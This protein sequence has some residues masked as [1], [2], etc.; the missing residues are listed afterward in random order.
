MHFVFPTFLYAFIALSIPII[1]HLFYFRKYKKVYFP[2]IRFLKKLQEQK[3][4]INQLKQRLILLARLAAIFFL[5]LAFAQ[6]FFGKKETGNASN[7]FS[8]VYIDNSPST[9]LVKNGETILDIEKNQAK[10]V[11]NALNPD[12]K[13]ALITNDLYNSYQRWM[14]KQDFIDA[15]D[16]IKPSKQ[17]KSLEEVFLKQNTLLESAGSNQK[18]RFIFS[19]F[20]T[21]IIDNLKID[22]N[23]TTYLLP[24]QTKGENNVFVDTCW[25]G[26]PI[27][28]LNTNNKLFVRFKNSG[29]K[30]V[31]NKPVTLKI[32]EQVKSVKEI[33]VAANSYSVDSFSF[34]IQKSGIQNIEVVFNDYPITYDDAFFASF[35]VKQNEHVLSVEDVE[36]TNHIA[37]IFSTDNYFIYT[38]NDVLQIDYSKLASY[39]FIVLN[40]VKEISSGL[41]NSLKI[42]IQNGGALFVIP[43]KD[44]NLESYNALFNNLGIGSISAIKTQK[45]AVQKLN[46]NEKIYQGVFVQI[47]KNIDL[48]KIEKYYPINFNAQRMHYDIMSS[49]TN[50]PLLS[51]FILGN[52]IF[53]IQSTPLD[54]SFSDIGAKAVYAPIVYNMALM[55]NYAS[56]LFY[57]IGKDNTISI[58]AVQ[59]SHQEQ[60]AITNQK[61]EFIPESRV[62][63]NTIFLNIKQA[64]ESDGF[65]QIKQGKQ[66]NLGNLA[67]NFDRKESELNFVTSKKLESRFDLPNFKILEQ[68]NSNIFAQVKHI[69]D[70]T[71][72]WKIFIVL[73]LLCLLI[74]I[75]LIRFLK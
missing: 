33:N 63:G 20:Q 56:P 13:I 59:N 40:Q 32:N 25:L 6:P 71:V 7:T 3:S 52:G 26:S 12:D 42:Y 49:T 38:K 5:V 22:T 55:K 47:P 44:I 24:I 16:K 65:Y 36:S 58:P 50:T 8:A 74:E 17:Q 18:N 27:V 11:A 31:T 68:K 75:L 37:A 70:G 73:A 29:E 61:Q 21:Y 9:Q 60:V 54:N 69:K 51:K 35:E 72:L 53:Y 10:Q 39:D 2:D 43:A 28:Q 30:V 67:F 23:F 66:T 62:L 48:P 45:A 57:T 4:N 14:T 34:S 1:I 15:V 19:D 64:L 41:I 46:L